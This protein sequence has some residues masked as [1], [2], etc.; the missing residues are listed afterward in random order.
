MARSRD[1][2][3]YESQQRSTF[4]ETMDTHNSSR[5][6]RSVSAIS[7][8]RWRSKSRDGSVSEDDLQHPR[9]F[10]TRNRQTMAFEDLSTPALTGG[11]SVASAQSGVVPFLAAVVPHAP[12]DLNFD[13][14]GKIDAATVASDVASGSKSGSRDN[15]FLMPEENHARSKSS[16]IVG[17]PKWASDDGPSSPTRRASAPE[18]RVPELKF[19]TDSG[20]EYLPENPYAGGLK[21]QVSKS[22]PR[23]G[24]TSDVDKRAPIKRVQ[25]SGPDPECCAM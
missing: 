14:V 6:S 24:S 21:P 16:D 18:I 9:T 10:R 20:E 4:L 3:V 19:T 17:N 8:L 7:G 15:R 13:I 11:S 23:D 1:R 25:K 12:L 2:P 5:L 22:E